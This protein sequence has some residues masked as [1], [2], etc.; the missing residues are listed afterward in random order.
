[1]QV[2][3]I[4]VYGG[5]T[6]GGDLKAGKEQREEEY[7]KISHKREQMWCHQSI[8]SKSWAKVR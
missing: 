2:D 3:K 4:Q 7:D 8:L 1:M 5:D 6:N